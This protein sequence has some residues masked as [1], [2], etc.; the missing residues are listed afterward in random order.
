MKKVGSVSRLRKD[1]CSGEPIVQGQRFVG[2]IVQR[3]ER[4]WC[5]AERQLGIDVTACDETPVYGAF[6]REFSIK[7]G[8]NF[9]FSD[10]VEQQD[11]ATVS[12]VVEGETLVGSMVEDCPR[13][14]NVSVGERIG[15]LSKKNFL[16]LGRG[17]LAGDGFGCGFM[18]DEGVLGNRQ[19]AGFKVRLDD[20]VR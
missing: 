20:T 12:V 4:G 5:F 19:I 9:R 2:E 17:W 11:V 15:D 14:N 10:V 1:G 13:N 6:L 16:R 3:R 8:R 18:D 7:N